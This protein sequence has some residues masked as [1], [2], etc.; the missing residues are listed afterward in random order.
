MTRSYKFIRIIMIL[1]FQVISKSV[2]KLLT[3]IGQS[4]RVGDHDH[5]YALAYYI[6]SRPSQAGKESK[7]PGTW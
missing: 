3:E 2:P 4:G 5:V 7:L 1:G 6:R